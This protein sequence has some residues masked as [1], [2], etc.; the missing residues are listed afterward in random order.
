MVWQPMQ[1]SSSTSIAL[2]QLNGTE[3][4]LCPA[5]GLPLELPPAPPVPDLTSVL[6][7]H[8]PA[9]V[10]ET[11][12][13]STAPPRA[14]TGFG[15]TKGTAFASIVRAPSLTRKKTLVAWRR[16]PRTRANNRENMSHFS[17]AARSI[18]GL[19]PL[20]RARRRQR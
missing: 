14:N 4:P 10:A 7:A 6:P 18:D 20:L 8:A 2:S 9:T 12:S 16:V 15:F 5:S 13:A 17:Y 1:L 19:R 11:A 3:T